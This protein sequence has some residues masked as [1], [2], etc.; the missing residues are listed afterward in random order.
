M[1]VVRDPFRVV[2]LRKA[3]ENA[4]L[5]LRLKLQQLGVKVEVSGDEVIRILR[6][7]LARKGGGQ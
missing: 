4:V 5:L 6:N 3:T 2:D 7:A 1:N